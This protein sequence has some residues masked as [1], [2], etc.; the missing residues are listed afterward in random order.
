MEPVK[1]LKRQEQV[2]LDAFLAR[3][4]LG[5]RKDVRGLLRRGRVTVDGEVCKDASRLL[6]REGAP[7]VV[8]DGEPVE[9]LPDTL[10]LLLH[11]PVGHACSH[12]ERESPIVEEL[13]PAPWRRLEL[14][15]AGRL[16]RATSGL[17]VLTTDGQ[18][19][20]RLTH[21]RRK[22]AKRYRV[23]CAGPLVDDAAERCRAGILLDDEPEPTRPALLEPAPD[24]DWWLTLWEGRTHQVR[25]MIQA[26]GSEVTALHRDR[27][28]ALDLPEDLA[29]GELRPLTDDELERLE[30]ESSL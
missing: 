17:L 8:V 14:R 23:T 18:R 25:R 1:G 3:A 30:S 13:L 24:G 28:G 29:P 2:R 7:P 9:A 4:G 22:I 21:P 16:D 19:V 6:P 5:S 27:V 15:M 20:H 11:K 26:L 12:D 10:H